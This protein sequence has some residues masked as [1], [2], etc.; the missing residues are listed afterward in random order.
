M[1]GRPDRELERADGGADRQV[2]G[3]AAGYIR[4]ALERVFLLELG[5]AGTV[6]VQRRG[7]KGGDSES[8]DEPES[9]ETMCL[10]NRRSLSRR[11]VET[12]PSGDGIFAMKG[13]GD[14]FIY[15]L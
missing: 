13:D 6:G 1:P 5:R 10:R 14:L 3:G 9:R 2:R 15:K 4:G 8:C 7:G 12:C 11:N